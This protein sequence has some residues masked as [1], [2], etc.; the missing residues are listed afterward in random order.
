MNELHFG[1]VVGINRYP[2]ISDLSYAR[3]DAESMHEWLIDRDGGGLCERNVALVCAD[4]AEEGTFTYRTARPT[5]QEVNDALDELNERATASVG[6]DPSRWEQTRLYVYVSGHGISPLDGK[7]GVLMANARL[8]ALGER[9]DLDRYADWYEKCAPFR[10]LVVFADCCRS[11]YDDAPP[12]LGP[13]WNVCHS[14]PSGRRVYAL[15][16]YATG[17]GGEALEP[18]AVADPD[19]QRGIFTRYLLKGLRKQAADPDTGE[20]TAAR[21]AEYVKAGVA[22]DTAHLTPPQEVDMIGSFTNGLVLARPPAAAPVRRTVTITFPDGFRGT[23]LLYEDA[24]PPQQREVRDG[25][26]WVMELRE[27][28]YQ[29]VS[30]EAEFADRGFFRVIGG[31]R[32]VKL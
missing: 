20:V 17:M 9:I 1:L 25:D 32:V 3:A 24:G 29:V 7:A 12:A 10:D 19:E 4:P 14:T 5:R 22:Q 15:M 30:A 11:R 2:G 23:A 28:M 18:V 26:P 6:G 13:P 16:S 31:D 8:T 27:G 21:L